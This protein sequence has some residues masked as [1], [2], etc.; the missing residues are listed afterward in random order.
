[1][2]CRHL[3]VWP[4]VRQMS[5]AVNI[6]QNFCKLRP[7]SMSSQ[8]WIRQIS[9]K[10]GQRKERRQR[11]DIR[12]DCDTSKKTQSRWK[13]ADSQVFQQNVHGRRCGGHQKV[14][15]HPEEENNASKTRL[16]EIRQ[17]CKKEAAESRDETESGR[18]AKK[19]R[20]IQGTFTEMECHIVNIHI[21]SSSHPAKW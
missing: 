8:L 3:S 2:F 1:M 11:S 10:V 20:Q 17:E 18:W 21:Y 7:K 5:G 12:S 13:A 9:E 16:V 14:D 19:K 4:P 6:Q 15:L